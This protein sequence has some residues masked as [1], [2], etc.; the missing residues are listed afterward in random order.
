MT[1]TRLPAKSTGAAGHSPVWNDSPR[2]SSR[3][4]RPGSTARRGHRSRRRGTGPELG[5][6]AGDDGPRPRR[7]VVRGRRD[8]RAE[9]DV[10]AEVEAVDDVVQVA[11]G[12]RL[13]GEV[14]LPLPFV[15][16]LLREQVRVGVALGVEPGAGVTVPVPR[17][18]D[19]AAG[20]EQL[21]REPGFAGAVQLV[22]AGDAGA[23]DEDVDC[24][25][26]L[27]VRRIP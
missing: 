26:R 27:L 4:G 17:A 15:E 16:E 1:A 25:P 3:P 14:L 9:A 18:A 23:D 11:L 10:A 21:H 5:A 13:F 8:L 2:K 12:L 20:L 6:V 7:L 19:T 22:D 24:S